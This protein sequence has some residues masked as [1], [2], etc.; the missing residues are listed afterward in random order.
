MPPR[1]QPYRLSWP[2]TAE[3][4]ESI[5][6]MLQILFDDVRN[7][8]IYPPKIADTVLHVN[9]DGTTVEWAK[10]D[11]T[12]T[13]INTLPVSSG[14]TGKTSFTP[15]AVITG[16]TTATNPLQSIASVGTGGQVLT[17]NGAGALPSFQAAS[18]SV[19]MAQVMTRVVIGI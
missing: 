15:F 18:G 11:L 17:S 9:V 16:G 5:D 4:L 1:P 19:T 2:L 10:V 13:V 14:G 7:D 12:S 8:S 3:Q 6:E